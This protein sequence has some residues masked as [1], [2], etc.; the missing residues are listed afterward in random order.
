VALTPATKLELSTPDL[1]EAIAAVSKV[2]CPHEVKILGSNRGVRTNLAA[3][4]RPQ[5]SIVSLR[6]SAPVHI[7]AG[8]FDN[9]MLMMTCTDGSARAGQGRQKVAW[10]RGQTLP[11]SPN[12]R[13]HLA[14]E[15]DFCQRS[16]RLDINAMEALCSRL[17]N[18]A[19]DKPL[20]FDFRTF[21][22]P[23]ERAWEEAVA[24]L[25]KYEELGIALPPASAHALEEFIGS[26]ILER[27][28][29]N[30]SDALSGPWQAAAPRVVKEAEQLMRSEQP[31]TVS[32]VAKRLGVSLRTL[33]L[34]FREYRHATPTQFL[35]NT[36]LEAAR[37]QLQAADANTTVTMIALANGFPHLARFAGYYRAAFGEYPSET[38]GRSRR[39]TNG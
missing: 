25:R 38:L 8:N 28:P 5:H 31:Q 34:G 32:L 21:S 23:L 15:R 39:R 16:V 2:Y 11:F 7:D 20:R 37:M 19:L 33:E 17:L 26:L 3:L 18:R 12:V 13:S 4:E 24:L 27:H 36:R 1:A 30:Y 29:H 22:G 6:Y 9:L 35:R 14:F 10:R